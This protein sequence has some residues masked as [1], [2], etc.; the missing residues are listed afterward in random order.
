MSRRE[1]RSEEQVISRLFGLEND[2]LAAQRAE[3]T[4]E[5]FLSLIQDPDNG[6][7]YVF[8]HGLDETEGA[9]VPPGT[10]YWEYSTLAEAERAYSQLLDEDRRAGEVVE[11]DTDEGLGD[12]ET[13]GAEVRDRYSASDEDLQI[14]EEDSV[15]EQAD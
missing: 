6:L 4:G 8:Q 1:E 15:G 13:G 10:E 12:S 2:G 5:R 7:G 9:E 11:T 3:L 14:E